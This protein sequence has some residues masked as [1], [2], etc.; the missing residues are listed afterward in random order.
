MITIYAYENTNFGNNDLV[1]N[2]PH[3]VYDYSQH[4]SHVFTDVN[5]RHPKFTDTIS[6]KTEW[7]D[8]L[9]YIDYIIVS[10]DNVK[11]AYYFVSSIVPEKGN[12]IF[13]VLLDVITSY[14][15]LSTPISGVLVRKHDVS[16]DEDRFDYPTALNV[17]GNYS[18]E[19]Y[20]FVS[21]TTPVTRFI[22]SAVNLS[23]IGTSVTIDSGNGRITVPT[24]LKP[25]HVTNYKLDTWSSGYIM[26]DNRAFTLYLN[27]SVDMTVLNTIRGLSGDGAISDSYAIPTEA[28][29]VENNG[30]EVTQLEGKLIS[31]SLG[32]KMELDTTRGLPLGTTPYV[33]KNEAIKGMFSVRFTSTQEKN[34]L[35][36]QGWDVKKSVDAYGYIEVNLWSDCKPSGAPFCC[37]TQVETLDPAGDDYLTR[38]AT[39]EV[40]SVKGGQWLRNP[41]IY[42]T[43]R[44]EIFATVETQLQR[45]RAAYENKTSL[46]Q[47]EISRRER[48]VRIA[49]ADF[50][51]Q[52][53]QLT[54]IIG[55]LGSLASKDIG[56]VLNSARGVVESSVNKKY[57]DEMRAVQSY[58]QSMNKQLITIAYANNLKNLNV[59]EAMRRIVPREVVFQSNE[60]LGGYEGYNGFTVTIIQPDLQT[61]IAKDVEYSKYGY[62]VYETVIDFNMLNNLRQNHTVFQFDKPTI[63]KGGKIGDMIR[64]VLQGGIRI[65]SKICT[66]SNLLNNPKL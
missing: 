11:V 61:L 30:A 1:W 60:S 62:P 48:E 45:E 55:G 49:Q 17:Q 37:P 41:L 29:T 9:S 52:S 26:D 27:D 13:S 5:I 28:I 21:F 54:N 35:T 18:I 20:E 44:G 50:N 8:S 40:K 14:N 63:S 56:G 23:R 3:P 22:E 7:V 47:L 66:P 38:L 34:S 12:V 15:V 33:P 25:D 32:L 2:V 19:T 31:K 46:F 10:E 4:A 57:I 39:M 59:Q 6:V 43:A 58:E 16:I 65:C 64:E 24:L 36:F 51:Y 42:S 53:G